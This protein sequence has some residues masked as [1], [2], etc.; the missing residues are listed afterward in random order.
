MLDDY[1]F[2][3]YIRLPSFD[4]SDLIFKAGHSRDYCCKKDY[5]AWDCVLG[6]LI[7]IDSLVKWRINERHYEY[8]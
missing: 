4:F 7:E 1:E 8:H 6:W 3:K 2:L 5:A